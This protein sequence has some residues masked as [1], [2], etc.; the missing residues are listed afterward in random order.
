M[1][2]RLFIASQ[3]LVV[4]GDDAVEHI[5]LRE[6]VHIGK[7]DF[8]HHR[9]VF[10]GQHRDLFL[11][12]LVETDAL[13]QHG[14]A[15]VAPDQILDRCDIVELQNHVEIADVHVVAFKV[16]GKQVA[17]AGVRQ[18]DD[19]ALLFQLVQRYHAALRKRVVHRNRKHQ[20]VRIEQQIVDGGRR[21]AALDDG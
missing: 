2:F 19:H 8:A 6:I 7:V 15:E 1:Y 20:T 11:F 5:D 10:H 18:T 12:Q 13:G 17:R 16:R 9:E 4:R 21:H 14:H 3:C